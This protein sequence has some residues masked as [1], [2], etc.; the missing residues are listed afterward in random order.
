MSE[1]DRMGAELRSQAR[2]R[3]PSAMPAQ[4]LPANPL[5]KTLADRLGISITQAGR[6]VGAVLAMARGFLTEQDYDV[7]AAAV[8]DAG[9][10]AEAAKAQGVVT[11]PIDDKDDLAAVFDQIG[12]PADAAA[13]F[14]PVMRA[15]LVY[16]GAPDAG[17]LVAR[18]M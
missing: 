18:V 6:G 7:I 2:E 3:W 13:N 12:I 16:Q 10:L 4:Y 15:W 14:V 9:Q 1:W 17:D 8:P 11:R 5:L